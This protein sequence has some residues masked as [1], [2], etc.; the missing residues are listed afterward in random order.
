MNW[1]FLMEIEVSPVETLASFVAYWTYFDI[2]CPQHDPTKGVYK[3]NVSKE[4]IEVNFNG[5][6]IT[7][8]HPLHMQWF[9]CWTHTL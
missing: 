6:E 3:P 7:P 9:E 2:T 4:T 5:A 8:F 1:G